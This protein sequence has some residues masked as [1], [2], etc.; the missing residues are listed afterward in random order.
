V[1]TAGP[2]CAGGGRR[3]VGCGTITIGTPDGWA[4]N[5][6]VPSGSAV[7]PRVAEP[8][9]IAASVGSDASETSRTTV[10]VQR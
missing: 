6:V 8:A 9:L 2:V 10:K 7:W 3:S 4:M 5:G 1:A